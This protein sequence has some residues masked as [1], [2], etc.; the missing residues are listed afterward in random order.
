MNDFTN[1]RI[2]ALNL[3][4]K[5]WPYEDGDAT[6]LDLA[7]RFLEFLQGTEGKTLRVWHKGDRVPQDVKRVK[8]ADG[9]VSERIE[10]NKWSYVQNPEG[11]KRAPCLSGW[12]YF[13]DFEHPLTEVL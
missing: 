3:A 8:T 5:A 7:K 6:V 4:I 13:D 2:A 10:G 1:T 12:D 9:W 11:E